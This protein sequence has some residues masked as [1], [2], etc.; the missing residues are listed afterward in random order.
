MPELIWK[1]YID[2]E[3]AEGNREGT[4]ELY[5][6]LL[7]RTKHVKVWMSFA[8]ME[9]SRLSELAE[10]GE[11]AEAAEVE[12]EEGEVA[13]REA[14]ARGVY[15]RAYQC[16]RNDQPDAKEEAVMLLEAWRAFEQRAA[17]RQEEGGDGAARAVEAVE[18][19]MPK[20]VKRKRP[21]LTD[22]GLEAGMEEYFDYIFPEEA[23]N[24]PNLKVRAPLHPSAP[25]GHF[26][27]IKP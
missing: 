6:R 7:E 17:A 24:A 26:P 1:A 19:R 27:S 15:E 4:R 23:G 18:K 5:E 25:L 22:E 12:E 9:A 20:R 11:A 21:I 10:E 2:F 14:A 3:I 13:A 8:K 16:L